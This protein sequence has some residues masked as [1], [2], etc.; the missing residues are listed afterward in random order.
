MGCIFYDYNYAR[1]MEKK[2]YSITIIS[3]TFI[4]EINNKSKNSVQLND[5]LRLIN[6]YS[7]F[8]SNN[9]NVNLNINKNVNNVVE[10]NPFPFVKIKLKGSKSYI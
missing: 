7:I 10:N 8:Q 6:N 5:N 1:D 9:T 2:D 3:N 4:N